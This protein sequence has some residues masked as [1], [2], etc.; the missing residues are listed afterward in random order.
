MI[1]ELK[2]EAVDGRLVNRVTGQ[3]IPEDEPVFIFRAKDKMAAGAMAVY[4]G[5]LPF[6]EHRSNVDKVI[7]AFRE[8]AENKPERMKNPD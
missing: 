4:R 1:N 8:F 2:Y 5:V 7:E 3:A 6:G